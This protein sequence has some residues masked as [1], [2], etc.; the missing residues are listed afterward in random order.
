MQGDFYIGGRLIQPR[1]NQ[2]EGPDG[3]VRVKPRSIAVLKHLAANAGEVVEKQALMDAVWGVSI[4]TDDVLTQS[5]VELR[6]AFDD[7]ANDPVFIETIR[8]VG[9]R[10]LPGVSAPGDAA[11]APTRRRWTVAVAGVIAATAV[12]VALL[13][14]PGPARESVA[15]L[16]F[17]NLSD[18]P[19]NDHFSDGLSEEILNALAN[20]PGLQVPARTSS[21]VF[22]DRNLDVREIGRLLNVAHVLEGSV[23]QDGDRLRVTAQLIDVESGYHLWAETYDRQTAGVFDVQRDIANRIAATLGVTLGDAPPQGTERADAYALYLLGRHHL[24]TQLGD[25]RADARAAFRGAIDLDPEFARAYAGLGDTYLIVR[26]TPRSFLGDSA[27]SPLALAHRAIEQALTIDPD[28]VSGLAS[29]ARLAT[30][31]L[32]LAAAEEDLHRA[33]ALNPRYAPI[34]I[35]MGEVLT[36]QGRLRDA[37]A[38]LE[39]AAKLDPLNPELAYQRARLLAQFGDYSGAQ[40]LAERLLD[41]GIVHPVLYLSLISTAAEYGRYVDRVRWALALLE[42]MPGDPVA[43]AELADAY[44]ELGELDVAEVWIARIAGSLAGYKARARLYAAQGRYDELLAF[45]RS[46][47]ASDPPQAGTRLSPGQSAPSAIGALAEFMHGDPAQGIALMQRI[48]D[49]SPTLRR[50][51]FYQRLYGR[52]W[53]IAALRRMGQQDDAAALL[54]DAM[55]ITQA[56]AVQGLLGHPPLLRE[57]AITEALTGEPIAIDSLERAVELGWRSVV[58]DGAE[59][60]RPLWSSMVGDPRLDA[61]L[62]HAR[63]DVA[64][65]RDTARAAGLVVEPP[66]I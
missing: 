65:M 61:A 52:N 21:F 49:E 32:D 11:A 2:V 20:V 51:E 50:R 24:N 27:E 44:M 34:R 17:V 8:R 35:Q 28:L 22:K 45:T 9:Y 63:A 30:L 56:A 55:S 1:L 54:A 23:R 6:K 58:L 59:H 48:S 39:T 66:A 60:N 43:I 26:E 14:L 47:I 13:L 57:I 33:V 46:T 12:A 41:A 10:L 40:A 16:P 38:E 53:M 3:A 62:D 42:L 29:R 15:V 5:I 64:H 37:A 19:A 36:A 7:N 25:W 18:A 4:V 31:R